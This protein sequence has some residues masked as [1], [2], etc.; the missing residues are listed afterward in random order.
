MRALGHS[1]VNEL[2]LGNDRRADVMGL[3]PSGDI[4]IVEIKSCVLDF[5]S[6]GKSYCDQ[7]YF[8]VSPDFPCHVIPQDSGL[9]LADWHGARLVREPGEERL[10]ATRRRR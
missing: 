6:D 8:A 9:M 5:Q 7:L 3:S 2:S 10:R 4:W 1:V